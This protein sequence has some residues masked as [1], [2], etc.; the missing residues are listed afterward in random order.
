MQ[1]SHEDHR[2]EGKAKNLALG[3]GAPVAP[4]PEAPAK[5]KKTTTRKRAAKKK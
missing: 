3:I 2:A 4:A 1:K 5:P